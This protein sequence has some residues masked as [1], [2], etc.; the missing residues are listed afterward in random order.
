MALLEVNFYEN[1][2]FSN[3]PI[4]LSISVKINCVTVCNKSCELEQMGLTVFTVTMI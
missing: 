3:W 4:Q 1:K 2:A